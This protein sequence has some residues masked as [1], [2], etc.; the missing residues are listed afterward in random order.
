[1][2]I[3]M[4]LTMPDVENSNEPFIV[5]AIQR[6][7][8]RR[9]ETSDTWSRGGLSAKVH[10]DTGLLGRATRS[11]DGD[12]K[13]RFTHHP[14]TGFAIEG[15]EIPQW[16]E[17]RTMLLRAARMV[18]VLEY[19]ACAIVIGDDDPLALE[20]N[21]N[22]AVN[23]FQPRNRLLIDRRVREYDRLRRVHVRN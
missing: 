15:V 22:S 11:P 13:E 12:Q 16:E 3:S 1:M 18:S 5:G 17:S 2:N 6:V 14:D 19:V 4:V 20:A 10:L 23:V 9:P 8:C 7:G 21:I